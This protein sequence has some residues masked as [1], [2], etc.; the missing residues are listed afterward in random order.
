VAWLR[1]PLACRVDEIQRAT[2]R[3]AGQGKRRTR[4]DPHRFTVVEAEQA[5]QLLES[6][7]A[8]GK[9]VAG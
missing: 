6:G 1:Q 2:T 8:A 7:K 9:G 4:L 5:C 3:L